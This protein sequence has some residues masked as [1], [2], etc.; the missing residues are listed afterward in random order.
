LVSL[1]TPGG[2]RGQYGHPYSQQQR[3]PDSRSPTMSMAAVTSR[4]AY[5]VGRDEVGGAVR[6]DT[7]PGRSGQ[8]PQLGWERANATV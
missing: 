3:S 8:V 1:P 2:R 7:D 5:E 6:W 4:F